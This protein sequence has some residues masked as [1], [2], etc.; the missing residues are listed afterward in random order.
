MTQDTERLRVLC[1]E[2]R[3]AL[4][5]QR[6]ANKRLV[7]ALMQTVVI[8]EALDSVHTVAGMD[9]DWSTL[10]V[11]LDQARAAIKAAEEGQP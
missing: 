7:E 5:R 10:A 2:L 1:D 9:V 3:L 11:T 8:M 4:R 6:E